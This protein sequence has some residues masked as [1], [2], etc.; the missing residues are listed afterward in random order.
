MRSVHDLSLI[1]PKTKRQAMKVLNFM[2]VARPEEL[3]RTGVG[4]KICV[5]IYDK[6]L[7]ASANAILLSVN[8]FYRFK[9]N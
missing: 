3:R 2:T 8:S 7:V 1:I 5:N 4:K 9:K 6:K